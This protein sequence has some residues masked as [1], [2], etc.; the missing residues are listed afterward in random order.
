MSRGRK[1]KVYDNKTVAKWLIETK[2]QHLDVSL[3]TKLP[4]FVDDCVYG[5]LYVYRGSENNT[6]L[7]VTPSVIYM[8]LMLNEISTQSV[9]T[10]C[11]ENGHTYSERTLRRIAQ[12]VR[13]IANGIE[14]KISGYKEAHDES[15]EKDTMF[16][17][18]LEQQ[19][20]WCYYNNV[21]SKLYSNPL[22]QIPDAIR[23]LYEDRNYQKYLEAVLEWRAN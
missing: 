9:M 3:K 16:N 12:I 1:P 17:W 13:F 11:V 15:K 8:C 14:L 6:T 23:K 5:G 4:T 21:H 2:Y 20:I 19:F 18:K 10:A 7:S 22:P